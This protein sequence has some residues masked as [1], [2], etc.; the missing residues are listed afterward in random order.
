MSAEVVG[1]RDGRTLLMPLGELTGIGPGT[2]VLASGAPF[3]V[4]VGEHLLGA[5]STGSVSPR[6]SAR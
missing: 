4:A 1:F 5:S 6:M 3:R 2:R